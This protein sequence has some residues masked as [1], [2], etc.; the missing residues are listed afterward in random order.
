MDSQTRKAYY[1]SY[2]EKNKEAILAKQRAYTALNADKIR[3]RKR[4]YNSTH[5]RTLSQ[6]YLDRI[7]RPD[8]ILKNG[9]RKILRNA[10]ASGKVSK[11]LDCEN[12]GVNN[13]VLEGHHEDYS[14]PLDVVWLCRRCHMALHRK[15]KY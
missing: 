9:A 1:K 8:F 6:A 12:C 15:Y 4:L 2:Y 7:Q 3:N 11:P 14:N 10:V 5:P 13:T